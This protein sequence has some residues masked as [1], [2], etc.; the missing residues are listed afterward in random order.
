MTRVYVSQCPA[1]WARRFHSILGPFTRF[2]WPRA[3][4]VNDVGRL[5]ATSGLRSTIEVLEW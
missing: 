2:K 4:Y 3:M 5:I 1:A